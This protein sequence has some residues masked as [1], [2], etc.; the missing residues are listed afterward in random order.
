MDV[1]SPIPGKPGDAIRNRRW[2]WPCATR[3]R[4]LQLQLDDYRASIEQLF[5]EHPDDDV[6]GS[7]PGVGPTLGPRLLSGVGA[8][9]EQYPDAQGL[10]CVAGTAPVSFNSGQIKRAKI[11]WH[12]DRF[13]RHTVHLWAGCSFEELSVGGGV[14]HGQGKPFQRIVSVIKHTAEKHGLI[15]VRADDIRFHDDVF[16]NVRTL[17]HG[18]SFGITVYERIEAEEPNANIGLEAGYGLSLKKSSSK[19]K[20]THHSTHQFYG[21]STLRFSLPSAPRPLQLSS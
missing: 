14:L 5:A 12:C 15:V 6:F 7:L 18:C 21:R 20:K 3:W 11:R 4:P 19:V 13:L 10:Q 17:L 1:F 9:R 2:R 16:G 8:N